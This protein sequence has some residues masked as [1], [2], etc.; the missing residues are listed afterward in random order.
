M[1]EE[2]AEHKTKPKTTRKRTTTKPIQPANAANSNG[3]G[4]FLGRLA[5]EFIFKANTTDEQKEAFVWVQD[6]F[7]RFTSGINNLFEYS[8]VKAR[9]VQSP[10]YEAYKIF[11]RNAARWANTAIANNWG[12][13]FEWQ[14]LHKRETNV[15]YPLKEEITNERERLCY[16]ISKRCYEHTL[17]IAE[18]LPLGQS[19]SNFATEMQVARGW[20]LDAINSNVQS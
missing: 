19:L 11:I 10:E 13:S 8:Q 17:G 4:E 1:S 16:E 7:K 6:Q 15:I 12:E 20:L 3:R 18:V 14:P 5:H 2:Q 9:L